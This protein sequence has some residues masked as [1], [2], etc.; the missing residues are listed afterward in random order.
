MC[1]LDHMKRTNY[2]FPKDLLARLKKAKEVTGVPMS[3]IIRR[4]V[5]EYLKKLGL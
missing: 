5:N 1:Y 3:E 2:Y 4:A